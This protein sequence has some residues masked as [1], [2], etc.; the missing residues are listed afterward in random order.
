MTEVLLLTWCQTTEPQPCA[1]L[2]PSPRPQPSPTRVR[3]ACR[4]WPISIKSTIIHRFKESLSMELHIKIWNAG[5]MKVLFPMSAPFTKLSFLT[6][7]SPPLCWKLMVKSCTPCW[8]HQALFWS[9][10]AEWD[11]LLFPHFLFISA[12]VPHF[13]PNPAHPYGK[14]NREGNALP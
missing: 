11:Y 3:A 4:V 1:P 8:S 6:S 2:R 7:P 9:K 14:K 5:A 13:L 12:W 10:C